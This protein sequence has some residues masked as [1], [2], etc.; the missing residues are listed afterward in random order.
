MANC[1]SRSDLVSCRFEIRI[2]WPIV[3][4]VTASPA[5]SK[6]ELPIVSVVTLSPAN[7]RIEIEWPIVSVVVASPANSKFE[8]P[9]GL[10]LLLLSVVIGGMQILFTTIHLCM[11]PLPRC[12]YIFKITRRIPV[13]QL[14][15]TSL[16]P[17]RSASTTYYC[18]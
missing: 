15:A 10:L 2:E 7:S 4:V 18:G 11:S 17:N 8:W 13:A 12:T 16:R 3:S 14:N 5:N 1:I 9:V 6:F